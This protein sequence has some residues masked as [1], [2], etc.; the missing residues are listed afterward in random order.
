MYFVSPIEA[1]FTRRSV[2]EGGQSHHRLAGK[3]FQFSYVFFNGAGHL[4]I[5]RFDLQL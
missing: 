2:N 4:A 1:K 3:D 5:C